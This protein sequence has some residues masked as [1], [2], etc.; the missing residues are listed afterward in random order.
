MKT[1]ALIVMLLN[2]DTS[3]YKMSILDT[4]DSARECGKYK[5]YVQRAFAGKGGSVSIRK[6]FKALR[7]KGFTTMYLECLPLS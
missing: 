4:Y 7:A 1:I 2:P 6:S 5:L 3:R